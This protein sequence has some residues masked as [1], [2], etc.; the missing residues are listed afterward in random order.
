MLRIVSIMRI[1][2]VATVF[3]AA[4]CRPVRPPVA[5]AGVDTQAA[6]SPAVAAPAQA[7]AEGAYNG[8]L[9]IG[10]MELDIVVTL[11]AKDGGDGSVTYSGTIDIPQQA[12]A[13]IPLHDIMVKRR[14]HAF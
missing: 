12:A 8:K 1:M 6:E 9:A 2:L 3:L 10:G 11:Q 14:G 4:G 7:P 13:G 5:T